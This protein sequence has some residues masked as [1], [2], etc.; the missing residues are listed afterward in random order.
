MLEIKNITKKFNDT[1]ALKELSLNLDDGIVGLVGHNGAGKST[2]LRCIADVYLLDEGEIFV[3]GK[4]NNDIEIKKNVFFL[5]DNPFFNRR[6]TIKDVFLLYSLGYKM[7]EKKFYE[8]I[9]LFHLP[10]NRRVDGFSK[11]M[12]RQLFIAIALSVEAKILLLD[13]AFDG[14][15]PLI[16]DQIKDLLLEKRKTSSLIIISSHNI[17]S[18]EKIV[19]QYV[20]LSNG[21]LKE[22][23]AKND[24][25]KTYVKYQMMTDLDLSSFD[26][27]SSSLDIVSLTT[28][29]SIYHLVLAKEENIE[30]KIRILFKPKLLENIPIDSSELIKASMKIDRE[31]KDDVH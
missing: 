27:A 25:S 5:S 3:D 9:D 4:N 26:I 16:T 23:K 30:D 19:D 11:G 13:E 6:S 15:D 18:L 17:G 2:L 7:D 12:L 31:E 14:L 22:N 28:V 8:I 20:I 1:V 29:G 24:Y 21:R 10:T